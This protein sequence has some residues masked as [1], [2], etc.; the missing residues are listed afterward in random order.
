[1]EKSQTKKTTILAFIKAGILSTI[2]ALLLI[3]LFA[4]ILKWTNLSDSFIMPINMLIKAISVCTGT[5]LLCRN[6][7]GGL[8]KGLILGVIFAFLSFIVFSILNSSFVFSLSLLTDFVFCAV[9]GAII[10]VVA[11]NLKKS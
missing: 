5:L 10:G 6:G 2:V 7:Q 4:F 3:L 11:V 1:M 8:I 9:C